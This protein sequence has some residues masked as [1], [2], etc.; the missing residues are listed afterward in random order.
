MTGNSSPSRPVGMPRRGDVEGVY[1]YVR[2]GDR[3]AYEALG[4]RFAADLGWP[5]NRWSVLMVWA[6]AGAPVT[7][8]A[9]P[10][11]PP[12]APVAPRPAGEK[13]G[14]AHLPLAA[15][16]AVN[17]LIRD[18]PGGHAAVPWAAP[19][20]PL[21]GDVEAAM[22]HAMRWLA[23]DGADAESGRSHLVH[24]AARLLIALECEL[25]GESRDERAA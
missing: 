23:R 10:V 21:V 17:G 25:R 15:L 4:W 22:R 11:T 12:A 24:A 13:P 6:G 5:H 20:R 14:F 16:G 1:R 19:G 2:H 9:A 3:A 8:P 7:P 18:N